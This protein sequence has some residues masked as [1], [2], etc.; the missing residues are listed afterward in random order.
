MHKTISEGRHF[1]TAQCLAK[2]QSDNQISCFNTKKC[3]RRFL[4]KDGFMAYAEWYCSVEC[5]QTDETVQELQKEVQD[6]LNS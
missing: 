1:C 2:Y 5:Q 3:Q 4:K 6:V